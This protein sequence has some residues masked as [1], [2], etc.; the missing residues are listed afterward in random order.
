MAQVGG[1]L[2]RLC[3]LG[4]SKSRLMAER[5]VLPVSSLLSPAGGSVAKLVASKIWTALSCMCRLSECAVAEGSGTA[6]RVLLTGSAAS[7]GAAFN[8]HAALLLPPRP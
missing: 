3:W 1:R 7:V 8:L 4:T 6:T 5:R 2:A